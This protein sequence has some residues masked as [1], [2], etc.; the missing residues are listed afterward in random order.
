[1]HK[2]IGQGEIGVLNEEGTDYVKL[3]NGDVITL[4]RKNEGN[5]L[6]ITG[7]IKESSEKSN[8]KDTIKTRRK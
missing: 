6:I 1:M 2:Y 5:G 7:E 4:T 3:K 8:E